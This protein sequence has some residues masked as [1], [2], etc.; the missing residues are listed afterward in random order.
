MVSPV[1][2]LNDSVRCS[3]KQSSPVVILGANKGEGV[4]RYKL[5]RNYVNRGAR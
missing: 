2:S 1:V 5:Q 3:K 4:N